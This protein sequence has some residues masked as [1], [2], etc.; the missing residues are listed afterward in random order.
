MRRAIL[1]NSARNSL[2]P[3]ITS[4]LDDFLML[5]FRKPPL[6]YGASLN[7]Y[8][9]ASAKI[10][11][12][13]T[14]HHILGLIYIPFG[15]VKFS[16]DKNVQMLALSLILHGAVGRI[17]ATVQHLLDAEKSPGTLACLHGFNLVTLVFCRFYLF[18]FAC[19]GAG[20]DYHI[21]DS[22]IGPTVE[23]V[24]DGC[25]LTMFLFNLFICKTSITRTLKWAKAYSEKGATEKA[26]K[27]K[28]VTSTRSK[29]AD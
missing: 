1:R 3:S 15:F 27:P 8:S 18:P 25:H 28:A 6:K 29:K 4:E 24:L 17:V 23:L 2:T 10:I 19:W 11:K 7:M 13:M 9:G 16:D 5:I 26:G 21:S 12:V 14:V 20:R 22:E